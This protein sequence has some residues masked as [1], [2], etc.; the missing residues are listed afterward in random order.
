MSEKIE[1]VIVGESEYPIVKKG[2]AQARQ[3]AA[4]GQWLSKYG[5]QMLDDFLNTDAVNAPQM[6]I[7][8]VGGLTEDSLLDLYMVVTG[9]SPEEADEYFDIAQLIDTA[10]AVYEQQPSVKKLVDRFFSDANSTDME[11]L[12]TTSEQP[13][14]GQTT[15]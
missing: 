15:K 9:C 4:L 6:I 10:I 12:P 1:V 13:T 14:D 5:N 7:G 8:I 2:R 3:V 11:E